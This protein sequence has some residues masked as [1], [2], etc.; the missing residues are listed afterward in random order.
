MF[1]VLRARRGAT[2]TYTPSCSVLASAAIAL[3]SPR[4]SLRA[5]GPAIA[6]PRPQPACI[7]WAG[8]GPRRTKAEPDALRT[9]SLARSLPRCIGHS[10]PAAVG[11]L[12][13][14][15]SP[16][17]AEPPEFLVL[18]LQA[19]RGQAL[20][21][22]EWF[23]GGDRKSSLASEWSVFAVG[24]LVEFRLSGGSWSPCRSA[25]SAW[26]VDGNAVGVAVVRLLD[27][28]CAGA[29]GDIQCEGVWAARAGAE[30]LCMTRWL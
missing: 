21:V 25:S 15:C 11:K 23:L 2:L 24:S 5:Q 18:G 20:A 22:A 8:A 28:H 3:P 10:G 13:R 12:H 4:S 17:H 19:P 9:R 26:G 6:D 27:W 14:F 30:D 16:E 1:L 29:D 7:A